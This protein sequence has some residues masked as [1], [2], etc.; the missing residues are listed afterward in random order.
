MSDEENTPA[1]DLPPLPEE[2]NDAPPLPEGEQ[3]ADIPPLPEEF[4]NE[5]APAATTPHA[6]Q[7][8]ANSGNG[9]MI[10]LTV[11]LV[12]WTIYGVFRTWENMQKA[13]EATLNTSINAKTEVLERKKEAECREHYERIAALV[14]PVR[15]LKTEIEEK[16]TELRQLRES[17]EEDAAAKSRNIDE[18]ENRLKEV[19]A[20]VAE[21]EEKL[22]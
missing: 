6:T 21:L 18:L 20:R 7:T 17:A 19:D 16:E 1:S 4:G 2:F 10:F 14:E 11:L 13:D 12:V 9:G 15:S 22:K 5:P 3:A 8:P